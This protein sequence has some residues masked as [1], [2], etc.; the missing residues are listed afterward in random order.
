MTAIDQ[1]IITVEVNTAYA[2]VQ[3]NP[4]IIQFSTYLALLK[5]PPNINEAFAS[6]EVN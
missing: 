5:N 3:W 6:T 1:F 2:E 4:G